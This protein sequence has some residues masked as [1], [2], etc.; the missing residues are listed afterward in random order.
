MLH[1]R[2]VGVHP[3]DHVGGRAGEGAEAL[4]ADVERILGLGEAGLELADVDVGVG[5]G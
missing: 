3:V 4:L 2:P 1:L 5:G